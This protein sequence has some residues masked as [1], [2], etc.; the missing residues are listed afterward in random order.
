M[1]FPGTYL[2]LLKK[3]DPANRMLPYF[4]RRFIFCNINAMQILIESTWY[5]GLKGAFAGES[6]AVWQKI[7]LPGSGIGEQ[8]ESG[9]PV[10]DRSLVMPTMLRTVPGCDPESLCEI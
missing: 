1:R 8:Q 6:K 2:L 7:R 3:G 5:L 4:N 10:V 9:I